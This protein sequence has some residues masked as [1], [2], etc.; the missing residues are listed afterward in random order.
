MRNFLKR[1]VHFS[2]T[3][4]VLCAVVIAI[5]LFLTALPT[6][7]LK[8]QI[9]EYFTVAVMPPPFPVTVDPE[10]KLIIEDPEVE[11]FLISQYEM[12]PAAA[13]LAEL[14]MEAIG[15]SIAQT[16]WYNFIAGSN[17]PKFVPIYSGYRKEEVVDMFGDVLGW[18]AA[19]RADFLARMAE[20]STLP[21]G[22]F[23]P[24]TYIV[25]RDATPEEI[26]TLMNR[27]FEQTITERYGTS[28]SERVPF[29]DAIIMASL[30]E[31]ETDDNEEMRIIAGIMW[32]RLFI[33][34]K[35]QIDATLQYVRGT[36]RN[37]W[38]PI[39]RSRDKYIDSPFNTYLYKG[40]PPS[41]ISNPSVAAVLAALN[42]KKTEC[43]FYF[44]D[45]DGG[46]HC[47]ETYEEHVKM[48]KKYYGRG[49]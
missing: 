33:D 45:Q 34:M 15:N 44:H 37:G 26:A 18:D 10:K 39:V 23:A 11:E 22:H 20:E 43:M 32:N 40:L 49:R 25:D 35:L 14:F 19:Q 27:R 38:W 8:D 4:Y 7:L 28:T 42:P 29:E 16:S 2:R 46:F 17:A 47:T 21:D 31:R 41:P 24:D 12:L 5:G 48:L 1:P 9:T 13:N 36:E 30:I 3:F 6:M